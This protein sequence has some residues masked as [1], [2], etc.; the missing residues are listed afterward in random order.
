[1]SEAAGELVA[2]RRD[3]RVRRAH[4]VPLWAGAVEILREAERFRGGRNG[5]DDE[6]L[7]FPS[8]RGKALDAATIVTDPARHCLA[9]DGAIRPDGAVAGRRRT[10]KGGE[11]RRC[12]RRAPH[13][14]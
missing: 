13:A 2:V 8:V 1:M 5:S 3:R 11:V 12:P 4:R 9:G 14:L 6:G 10:L 7:V